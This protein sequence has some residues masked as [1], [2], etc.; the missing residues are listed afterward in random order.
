MSKEIKVALITVL[1]GVILFFGVRFLKGIDVF[2]NVNTYYTIYQKIDG[3]QVSNPVILNGLPVGRVS[4]IEILQERNNQLLV[5]LEI[6]DELVIKDQTEALLTDPELLGDKAIA[7]NIKGNNNLASGDTLASVIDEGITG[8]IEEKANPII[9]ALDSTL[10]SLNSMLK[11]YKGM[12]ENVQATMANAAAIT[13]KVKRVRMD[14][15]N[16]A[17]SNFRQV[18]ADL[19]KAS[20]DL[21]PLAENV[22]AVSDSLKEIPIKQLAAEVQETNDRL[23]SILKSIDESE[24]TAGLI[25]N[26]KALYN[27]LD[28][29]I[30]DLDKLFIDLRENPKRYVHFSLFGRKDK[31]KKKNKQNQDSEQ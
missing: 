11:E 27:D 20:K 14:E 21:E 6:N 16:G 25:V 5:S 17:I 18:S 22:S 1:A 9:E 10:Y 23:K 28:Q 19:A 29:T 30:K 2:S 24:G 13:D 31:S 3:L 7:L 4:K 12:G 8:L 26:D 15:I